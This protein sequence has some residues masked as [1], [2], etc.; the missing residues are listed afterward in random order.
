[1]QNVHCFSVLTLS[2]TNAPLALR[3]ASDSPD[4]NRLPVPGVLEE[5]FITVCLCLLQVVPVTGFALPYFSFLHL[6]CQ[7]IHRV[8]LFVLIKLAFLNIKRLDL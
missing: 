3:P 4:S 1:M 6:Y 5:E 8:F 2:P 7:D